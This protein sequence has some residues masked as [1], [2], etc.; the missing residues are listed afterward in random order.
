MR[1]IFAFKNKINGRIHHGFY[2]YYRGYYNA[3]TNDDKTFA[4]LR[5][6]LGGVDVWLVCMC[7][8]GR[9]GVGPNTI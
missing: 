9:G 3:R 7:G 1:L 8:E 6:R 4:E 2:Q 5:A